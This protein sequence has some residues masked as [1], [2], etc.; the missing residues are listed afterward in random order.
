MQS[1]TTLAIDVLVAYL[2][3][4]FY[5]FYYVQDN[6]ENKF[7]HKCLEVCFRTPTPSG[8]EDFPLRKKERSLK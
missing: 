3:F 7:L 1:F 8:Q 2:G 4:Y 6:K 5:I